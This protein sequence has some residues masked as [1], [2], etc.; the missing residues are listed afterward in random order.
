M[1]AGRPKGTGGA[2]FYVYRIFDRH[3]TVYVGKGCGRRVHD[4][5]RRFR[6]NGEIIERCETDDEAFAAERRWIAML[7]PTQNVSPGGNGGRSKPRVLTAEER[8][9]LKAWRDFEREYE[10][11]GPRRYVARG[12]VTRLSEANIA[13]LGVSKVEL[14]RLWEVANGPRC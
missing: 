11:V 9:N 2:R 10:R 12:L 8:G 6:C 4:Q 3:E 7:R 14:S 5:R 1:P 13:S